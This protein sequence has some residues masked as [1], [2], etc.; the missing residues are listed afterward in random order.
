MKKLIT[1]LTLLL[2]CITIKADEWD[3]LR[4]TFPRQH[5]EIEILEL[6]VSSGLDQETDESHKIFSENV[7]NEILV[8]VVFN[9]FY[10][11]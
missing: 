11:S 7:N 2:L 1:F 8:V 3:Q 6:A 10:I 4:S 5:K 9:F